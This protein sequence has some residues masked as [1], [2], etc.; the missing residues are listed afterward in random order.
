M[1]EELFQSGKAGR[2]EK[3]PAEPEVRLAR[4][5]QSFWRLGEDAP[6]EAY[7]YAITGIREAESALPGAQVQA[8]LR[9][10]CEAWYREASSG[11]HCASG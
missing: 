6:M 3:A 4:A 11:A 1:L 8:I 2:A 5:Y 7:D 10:A 9:Q